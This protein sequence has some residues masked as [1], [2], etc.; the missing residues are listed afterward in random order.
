ML[1]FTTTTTSAHKSFN[2][3]IILIDAGHGIMMVGPKGLMVVLKRY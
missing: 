1:L 3:Y 2:E